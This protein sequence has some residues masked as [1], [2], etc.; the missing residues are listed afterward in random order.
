MGIVHLHMRYTYIVQEYVEL[1]RTLKK[2][3]SFLD[4]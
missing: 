3:V 1:L 2:G 4:V